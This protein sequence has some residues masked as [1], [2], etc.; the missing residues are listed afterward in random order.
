MPLMCYVVL[1]ALNTTQT[2][3]LKVSSLSWSRSQC[4]FPG[5]VP[6]SSST[7]WWRRSQFW[8]IMHR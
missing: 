2:S 7:E 6:S 8:W 3:E 4:K 5:H 1:R